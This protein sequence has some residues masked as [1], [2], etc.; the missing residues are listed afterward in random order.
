MTSSLVTA[1]WVC[2]SSFYTVGFSFSV[3]VSTVLLFFIF[4]S[5]TVWVAMVTLVVLEVSATVLAALVLGSVDLGSTADV[6]GL[7]IVVLAEFFVL[8]AADFWGSDDV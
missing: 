1:V 7:E 5:G 3:C 8:V 4:F 2:F 6:L